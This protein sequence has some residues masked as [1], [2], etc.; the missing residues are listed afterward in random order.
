MAHEASWQPIL[1]GSDDE[2]PWF[3]DDP[4]NLLDALSHVLQR[5]AWHARAACRGRGPDQFFSGNPN[6]V[7]GALALCERCEVQ[8]DCLT[9]GLHEKHGIWAGTSERTRRR[10]RPRQRTSS[11]DDNAA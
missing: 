4:A 9:V 1:T 11:T 8:A 5:P 3:P 6:T 7:R 2:E 10:L